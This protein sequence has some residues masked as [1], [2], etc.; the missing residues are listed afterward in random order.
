[1]IETAIIPTWKRSAWLLCFKLTDRFY[2][3]VVIICSGFYQYRYWHKKIF[4]YF[5]NST[6]AKKFR[7]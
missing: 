1:M 6:S 5:E 4:N 2:G 7:L 3:P